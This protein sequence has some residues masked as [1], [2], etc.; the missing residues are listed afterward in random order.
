MRSV[1]EGEDPD[2]GDDDDDEEDEGDTA[3]WRANPGIVYRLVKGQLKKLE[4]GMRK[5]EQIAE[6]AS[7]KLQVL[8]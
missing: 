8:H 6:K 4:D 2:Q 5:Y 3:E 7:K 1:V